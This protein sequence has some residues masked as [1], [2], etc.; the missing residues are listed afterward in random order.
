[1]AGNLWGPDVAQLRTLA[2]Q[3]GKRSESLQQQSTT[4][5]SAINNNTA[6]KGADGARF[7]SEWNGSHRAL[8]QKTALALKAE[9]K[10]L[11]THAGGFRRKGHY[12]RQ[13]ELEA[14]NQGFTVEEY[15]VNK[16]SAGS[17]VEP[18]NSAGGLL[19][20][21]VLISLIFIVIVVAVV[22]V[23]MDGVSP[24]WME[25]GIAFATVLFLVPTSSAYYLKER[26]AVRLRRASG[27]TPQHPTR[28]SIVRDWIRGQA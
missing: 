16:G 19:F 26:K 15:G 17:G 27:T 24:N 8:V 18:T 14:A 11:L 21:A 22:G 25:F 6:W 10:R 4:L 2:Q 5:T 28:R 20:L 1:M 23:L 12:K 13:I 3:F 9:S 7:T